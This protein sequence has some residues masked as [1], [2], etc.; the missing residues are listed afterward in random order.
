MRTELVATVGETDLTV[1]LERSGDGWTL[2][3][4]NQRIAVDAVRLADGRWSIIAD[5]R[6]LVVDLGAAASERSAVAGGHA[7]SIQ[8]ESAR[9]R[10]LRALGKR[11]PEARRGEKIRA[12]IAG[13]VVKLHV[14]VGD[15]IAAGDSVVV[16]E[17]MKMENELRASRDGVVA[18]IAVSAGDSV[19]TNQLLLAIE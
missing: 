10:Q 4:D 17:A 1:C 14:A 16:L 8:L 9:A 18:S 15:A 3:R 13:K 11:G 7:L 12:P 6:S 5:G 19:D 2:E